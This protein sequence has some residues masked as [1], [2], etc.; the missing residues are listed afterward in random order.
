VSATSP[1]ALRFP[2]AAQPLNKRKGKSA[3]GETMIKTR[4]KV[5]SSEGKELREYRR[6][7]R[8]GARRSYWEWSILLQDDSSSLSLSLSLSLARFMPRALPLPLRARSSFCSPR[9]WRHQKSLPLLTADF[10][11]CT[12]FSRN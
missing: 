6:L 10:F 2:V 8:P 4:R 12:S 7:A 9:P 5:D 3:R 1:T 11:S